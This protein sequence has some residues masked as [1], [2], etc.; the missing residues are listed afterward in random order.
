V[1]DMDVCMLVVVVMLCIVVVMLVIHQ[2]SFLRPP[3]LPSTSSQAVFKTAFAKS[4][5]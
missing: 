3:I 2:Q 4:K 5:L 1:S